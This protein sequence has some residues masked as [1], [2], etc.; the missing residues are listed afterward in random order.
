MYELTSPCFVLFKGVSCN[1]GEVVFGCVLDWDLDKKLVLVSLTPELVAERKA[2]EAHKGKQK[3]VKLL[4]IV[5]A[6]RRN[7]KVEDTCSVRPYSAFGCVVTQHSLQISLMLLY[8]TFLLVF[9]AFVLLQLRSGRIIDA[10]VQLIR[11]N[12]IVVTLPQHNYRLAYAPTKLVRIEMCLLR[13]FHKCA[14]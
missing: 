2:V 3:K 5:L 6:K 7:A 13:L 9:L 10:C 1:P 14:L 8:Q 4:K 11:D 12:Y